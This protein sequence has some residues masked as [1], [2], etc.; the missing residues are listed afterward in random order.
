[1]TEKRWWLESRPVEDSDRVS[2]IVV[3]ESIHR[4]RRGEDAY[5]T[6]YVG[7]HPFNP[8]GIGVDAAVDW[9]PLW[10]EPARS[11]ARRSRS[12]RKRRSTVTPRGATTTG[13]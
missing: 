9:L 4:N 5:R 2:I 13:T 6:P 12:K 7:H 8:T 11:E 10:E 3:E 1:M